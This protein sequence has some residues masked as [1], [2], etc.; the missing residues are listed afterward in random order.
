M[1]VGILFEQDLKDN[2]TEKYEIIDDF[3]EKNKK[4]ERITLF[5]K[6]TESSHFNF[7]EIIK[8]N[9]TDKLHMVN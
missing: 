5:S 1:P 4:F 6:I 2:F 9:F 3:I 8:E 7:L